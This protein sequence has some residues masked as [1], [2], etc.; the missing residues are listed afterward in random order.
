MGRG[1]LRPLVVIALL[2]AIVGLRG[3][4][5]PAAGGERTDGGAAADASFEDELLI[6]PREG[7]RTDFSRRTVPLIQFQPGGPGRDGIPAIDRPHPVPVPVA[8]DWL[9]DDEPVIEVIA[10]GEARAYPVQILVWHE[11]V[12][13][14]LG[15]EPI[16]VTYC[17][18]CNS[19]LAFERHVDGRTLSFGTTGN[20]RRFNLVMYDRETESW[21]QQLDGAALVGEL[22][23]S[24]LAPI[25]APMRAWR[26]FTRDHP[27]GTVLREAGNPRPYGFNPY[28]GLDQPTRSATE[29]GTRAA[30]GSAPTCAEGNDRRLPPRERV[31]LIEQSGDA[32]AIPFTALRRTPVTRVR[33]GGEDLVVRWQPGQRSAFSGSDDDA[34]DR[35]GSADVRSAA[36]G[37]RV[38]AST[39]FWF[40]VAA[41][42]PGI[43]IR[44]NEPE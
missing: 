21:W 24:E 16:A 26:E 38:P 2:A 14:T 43:R 44:F 37:K 10:G 40:A 15:G 5:L 20:L 27:G 8:D 12:N 32:L 7:W 28:V 11:I 23:G 42:N 18:L 29:C 25:A 36:T 39:P 19:A 13:D 9:D 22:A 4:S 34:D 33:V 6:V 1:A 35:V 17:P 30:L 3:A 31:V 41:A